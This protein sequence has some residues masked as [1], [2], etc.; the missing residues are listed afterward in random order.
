MKKPKM[1]DMI[2]SVYKSRPNPVIKIYWDKDDK[3]PVTGQC[4]HCLMSFPDLLWASY[5]SFCGQRLK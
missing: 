1:F 2:E 5:C 4:P 3:E